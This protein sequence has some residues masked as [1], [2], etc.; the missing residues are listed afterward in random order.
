[1]VKTQGINLSLYTWSVN[2]FIFER[3]FLFVILCIRWKI[4]SINII[5]EELLR[6]LTP[7]TKW[8]KTLTGNR[9]LFLALI[10]LKSERRTWSYQSY[11]RLPLRTHSDPIILEILTAW[12]LRQRYNFKQNLKHLLV[13]NIKQTISRMVTHLLYCR[14][15]HSVCF[16]KISINI[17]IKETIR[18]SICSVCNYL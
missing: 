2:I 12:E 15:I 7:L 18:Y 14:F 11:P 10:W 6:F 13:K 16:C 9:H 3:K 17:F 5:A 1:M 8:N 4:C